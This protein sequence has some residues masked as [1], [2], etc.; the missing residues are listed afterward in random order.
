MNKSSF[1]VLQKGLPWLCVCMCRVRSVPGQAKNTCTG[2][3]DRADVNCK[4]FITVGTDKNKCGRLGSSGIQWPHQKM[5]QG[6]LE[7]GSYPENFGQ[8]HTHS[9]I[10]INQLLFG[11]TVLNV[12][13]FALIEFIF[14]TLDSREY[15][16]ENQISK[17]LYH[18][19]ILKGSRIFL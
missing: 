1:I 9:Q 11:Y 18:E 19:K 14:W 5:P 13:V 12:V 10:F 15:S 2:T 7:L 16:R 4:Y 17:Q 8:V 6:Y 3:G